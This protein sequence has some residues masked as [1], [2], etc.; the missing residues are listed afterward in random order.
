MYNKAD[1]IVS[2]GSVLPLSK[3]DRLAKI[4]RRRILAKRLKKKSGDREF[5]WRPMED[6]KVKEFK[7]SGIA[8]EAFIK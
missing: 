1:F 7:N 2:S 3:L 6:R 5:N 4:M 8:K